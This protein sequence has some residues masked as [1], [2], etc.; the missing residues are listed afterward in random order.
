M[1]AG[2]EVSIFDNRLLY[3]EQAHAELS[4]WGERPIWEKY[5]QLV[6]WWTACKAQILLLAFC[7]S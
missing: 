2:Q 6:V 5:A 3:F 1:R 7:H 4:K